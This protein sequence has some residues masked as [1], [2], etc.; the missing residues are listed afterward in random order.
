MENREEMDKRNKKVILAV[1]MIVM[2]V[3]VL[4]TTTYAFFT[5]SRT[6][7]R[8]NQLVTGRIKLEFED[9]QNNINLTNQF[10]MS[11]EEAVVYTSPVEGEVA[12]TD[13]TVSG[14]AGSNTTLQYVVK[15]IKGEAV[16]GRIRMPDEHIKLYITS[17]T[18]GVGSVEINPLYGAAD[19]DAGTYG[20]LVSAGNE[21]TDTA[22]DGEVMLAVGTVGTTD[23]VH[24]YT[25]RMW[26][27]DTVKISDT[28]TPSTYCASEEECHDPANKNIYSKMFYSIKLKVENY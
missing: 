25:L 22:N 14:Y 24:S 15:A 17:T 21:G 7:E 28:Y 1:I 6:G 2:L 20:A 10:P 12:F 26:I 13:F 27:S 11:D 23:T 8:N 19:A 3:T 16:D 18:N 5:Y 9:G 4:I